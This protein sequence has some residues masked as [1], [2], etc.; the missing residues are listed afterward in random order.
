M[1][2]IFSLLVVAQILCGTLFAQENNGKITLDIYIDP[3]ALFDANAGPMFQMPF[4]KA[5]YFLSSDVAV[6]LGF[7]LG[8]GTDKN[9]TDADGEDYV[10]S[11]SFNFELAP[12][13]EKQFGGDKFDAFIGVELPITSYSYNTETKVGDVTV[14]NK[15]PNGTGYFG[16][17]LSG[18]IG[19]DYYV[20]E[21]VYVGAEF[22]PGL[23][24]YKNSDIVNDGTVTQKGGTQ[25][26]FSISSA[27]GIR[28]GVRF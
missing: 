14:S 28:L 12:G 26:G 8:F 9:Y 15:N 23:M 11:T 25:I 20:L 1:K 24:F 5:R 6:R 27:S 16:V 22:S 7:D 2:K 4:I 17:G 3:A 21:N 13:I 10:K 18:V 19:C